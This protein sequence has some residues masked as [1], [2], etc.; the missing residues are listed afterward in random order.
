MKTFR[1]I[2]MALMAVLL[3]VNFMACSSNDDE[4][5][6]NGGTTNTTKKLMKITENNGDYIAFE[7]DADGKLLSK[8]Q[9]EYGY[10]WIVE[11]TW[12]EDVITARDRDD[13]SVVIYRLQNGLV[14]TIETTDYY[15]SDIEYLTY[16]SSNHIIT[17]DDDNFTWE[18]NKVVKIQNWEKH[19]EYT[20]TGIKHKGWAP[21]LGSDS[22]LWGAF[23]QN[24]RDE[25]FYAYPNMF[26]LKDYELP[27]TRKVRHGDHI[28]T[29]KYTYTFY[30]DGYVMNLIMENI[31]DGDKTIYTYIWE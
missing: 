13:N 10:K 6:E 7:Y 16:D 22:S 11:Y 25:L 23:N 29:Y 20:Y 18:S 31:E 24:I 1:F 15:D 9:T 5:N 3:S 19:I 30:E 17:I 12:G 8:T 21:T 26:G 28:D 27:S 2:E 14:E 4:P